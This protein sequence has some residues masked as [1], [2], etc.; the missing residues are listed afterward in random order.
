MAL[1]VLTQIN[2]SAGENPDGDSGLHFT[3]GLLQALVRLEEDFH[4]YVLVPD[5]HREV[6]A[7]A[8][9]HQRITPIPMA[10][11]PR[12]HGGDFQ[13]SP[14]ELL[15][16][17]DC[18]R[19]DV[20]VLFLN[21]LE[22]ANAFL[23]FFNRLTFHNLPAISYV[24]WFDTRRP[25][26]PK[27]TMHQPALIAALGGM[28]ASSSVGCNS[29]FGREQIVSQGRKWFREEVINDL[30][31]RMTLLPPGV[32]VAA[33]EGARVGSTRDG[34]RRI[35]VNHRLLKYTGV[36]TLL[37]DTFPR[38][39]RQRTDFSVHVTNPTRVRLPSQI[40]NAP[41]LRVQTLDRAE[42]LRQ[43]WKSDIVVAPHRSC[44]WSMSTLEAICAE[45]VPLM[46][47]ESFFPE[48]LRPLLDDEISEHVKDRWMY[49]RGRLIPRLHELLDNLGAEKRVA[50][51]VALR[52]R[53]TYS[54]D[55]LAPQWRDLF[56]EHESRIPVMSDDNPSMR[57]ISAHLL[58]VQQASKEEILR[59][60]KWAPKQRAL[61]WTA[62]RHSLKQITH[63]DATN[64]EA[65]F[66]MRQK[67]AR[68]A[69]STERGR[70]A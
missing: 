25:S 6:W 69:R 26:T 10:L 8:L 66:K 46:N 12:L 49:F 16:N 19:F 5:R 47:Q 54:W 28:V 42:Y 62:F 53:Q 33:I 65:I 67:P 68:S 59:L 36:R 56:R 13:F 40:T 34:V 38:L 18:R 48:M 58:Q 63:E 24:H 3:A 17:F 52:A 39:W 11:E 2:Y 60:L 29:A 23:Q 21:Q 30:E 64:P 37:T 14:A 55:A 35:L 32:D 61:S 15:Q 70:K 41:W 44:H 57:R 7:A 31:K 22:T 45:C 50:R 27:D 4:F 43:L 51:T 20:D 9:Q 1:R